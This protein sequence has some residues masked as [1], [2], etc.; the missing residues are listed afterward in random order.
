MLKLLKA[1][2]KVLPD[3][4][5][6][7][8]ADKHGL[9]R[10]QRKLFYKAASMLEEDLERH[11]NYLGQPNYPIV[12]ANLVREERKQ[13][14]LEASKKIIAEIEDQ[15]IKHALEEVTRRISKLFAPMPYYNEFTPETKVYYDRIISL[16]DNLASLSMDDI[17]AE[18]KSIRKGFKTIP[19]MPP[20]SEYSL[21]VY[22]IFDSFYRRKDLTLKHVSDLVGMLKWQEN[23]MEGSHMNILFAVENHPSKKFEGALQEHLDWVKA[24]HDE[25]KIGSSDRAEFSSQKSYLEKEILPLCS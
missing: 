5:D 8:I 15:K 24:R 14:F 12:W 3:P 18:L 20:W 2:S 6:S 19:N 23:S 1:L 10:K 7:E 13:E 11:F 25:A 17:I 22:E 16:H 9:D 21:Y 4:K